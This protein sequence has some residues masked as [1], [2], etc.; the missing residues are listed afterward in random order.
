MAIIGRI[1]KRGGLAVT[2]VAIAILA[3]IFS[4]LLTKNRG[5]G[6]P[7]KVASIDKMDININEYNSR[8]EMSENNMRQQMPEGKMS[9]E[10]SFQAKIMAFQQLVSEK[11]LARE[12]DALGITVGED[13]LNDMFLGTFVSNV[14]RQQFTDPT[15]GQY[16]AQNVRQIMSQYDKM[17]PEQ[18]AAWQEIRR[19]AVDERIQQKYGI[20]L[21]KSFYMPKAMA[22]HLSDVYDQTADTRYAVLPYSSIDDNQIKLS[23]KDFETYYNEHKNQFF[24]SD[25]TR[26]VEFVKFDVQPS[27]ADIKTINDSV[28][29]LFE[30]IQTT[31]NE[32]MEAFVS[33]VSDV[34]YDSTYYKRTDRAV[35]AYFPDSVLAGKTAGSYLTPRQIGNNWVMGKVMSE[36]SRPDS[37][38]FAVIAIF[39]NKIGAEQI[40]RTPEQEKT[41]VDS[42]YGVIS[43]NTSLFEENVVKFSDDP[44]TKDKFGDQGWVLDGQ[45]MEDMFQPMIST[46][47]NGVFVYTRPDGAGDYLIKVTG[48]TELQPKIRLAH[49]VMGIRPSEKTIND[50]KDEANIFLSHAKDLKAMEAQAQKKN[51]N[52]NSS[53]IGQLSY[54]LDGTPYAREVVSWAYGKK[55]KEGEVAPEIYELQ[56]IDNFQD[57][58]VVVGL[59]T[60][61]PKGIIPLETLKKDPNFERLVKIEKKAE[62]LL[63][64]ANDALKS[65][66]TIEDFVAKTGASMDV[67]SLGNGIVIPV[68]F[69]TPYY[70]QAGGE[71][72]VLGTISA[73]KNKGLTKPIKGFNGV[74]VVSIDNIS[75]RAV[76]EDV[77]AIRQ[78]YQNR[79]N[80]RMNRLSPIGVMYEMADIDNY[81]VR[82]ISK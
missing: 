47:V 28:V 12:C 56:N 50:V 14:A 80:Q 10:Q 34:K 37:V 45:I 38:K 70:G 62:Q 23:D 66:K 76:K 41:L 26:E 4:D 67:D 60:I 68:D 46:P 13:E 52:L 48:K 75:K 18:Q 74:Y 27:P 9:Q 63:A 1:R 19:T 29:K 31:P 15:T 24:Q 58:F 44:T 65:A 21:A 72:R 22:K 35:T 17:Q 43:K 54:Q 3:F 78:T 8:S 64:K 33:S 5:E 51:L 25:E 16:N 49:V 55:V 81:F 69:S 20:V 7:T 73:Q 39:N 32:E 59:K 42:L 79:M 82:Y 53:Y 6:M 30:E 2:I 40:K 11:L 71:M 36:Q 77:N 61:Q 57:M